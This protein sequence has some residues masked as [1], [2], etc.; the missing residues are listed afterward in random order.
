MVERIRRPIVLLAIAIGVGLGLAVTLRE[1]RASSPTPQLPDVVADAPDN[2]SLAV[3]EETPTHE[4]TSAKLLLR[5]NGYVHNIGPG[6]LDFR[7][8]RETPTPGEPAAPPMNV[9]QRIYN[10]D[11]TYTEEPSKA[12]MVYVDA[13]G[14]HHWHLQ[15]VAFYSLWNAGQSAEVAP[16]QKVGFCLEDSERMEETGPSEPVYSDSGNPPREFCR[17][18]QPEATSVFEGIS[19]GWRDLYRS[20]LAFQ[21]VDISNVLPGEYW[22]R[23][24]ADPDHLIQQTG[25][26]KPPAYA[27][28][29]TVVPGFDAEAQSRGVAVEQPLT[30]TLTTQRWAGS[31]PFEQPSATPS[32]VIVTPPTHGT[33]SAIAV[34][35]VKYTPANGYSGTDSFTFAASDPASSF[36]QSPA[37]A[38]VSLDVSDNPPPPSV[39]IEGAPANMIAGTSVQLSALVSNDTPVVTW[40]AN[41]G[42]ISSTGPSRAIYTAP[43]S[44][45]PGGS[46]TLSAESPGGGR[47]QRAIEILPIPSPQPKPEVPLQ[48]LLSTTPSS[49]PLAPTSGPAS[50]YPAGFRGPVSTPGAM[51]IGRKLYMTA[52]AKEA[53]RLRLTAVLR[54]RHI[55]SCVT[56]VRSHQSFTCVTTL[57]RGVSTHT[58]ISVWATLRAGSHLIQTVRRAALVPTAMKA[59]YAVSWR[60]VKRAWRF[61][62]GM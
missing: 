13:D 7:G 45:P 11:G 50:S 55:G 4:H 24:E 36:P 47:D 12:Q 48:S 19:E 10:S 23:A 34:N 20:D 40:G 32:Y 38:T 39:A 2:I 56:R 5:F 33:L 43:S 14:H 61:F 16:A 35:R 8:S 17:E 54:G 21:W 49:A 58:P 41:A 62:C 44:T 59:T 3:S 57:P 42:S 37:V 18:H 60:S 6:A 29:P 28:K 9:F 26:E 30:V 1:A 52:I 51:L 15:Q 22:L 53:G 31:A 46:V 27:T 25:G